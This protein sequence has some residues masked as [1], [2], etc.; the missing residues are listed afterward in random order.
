MLLPSNLLLLT[1]R[2]LCVARQYRLPGLNQAGNAIHFMIPTQT[3]TPMAAFL[4]HQSLMILSL[5]MNHM[6]GNRHFSVGSMVTMP[7]PN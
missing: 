3:V 6:E 1:K 4:D 2:K 7:S 5:E